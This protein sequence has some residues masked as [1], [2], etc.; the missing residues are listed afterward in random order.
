MALFESIT[1]AIKSIYSY[2]MR[3]V[4]TMLGI[5]IGISSVIMITSI[6]DGVYQ[7][8]Y[9]EL[10]A[11]NTTSI[12]AM[13]RNMFGPP[14]LELDDMHAAKALPNVINVTGML[15]LGG[16][17]LAL[18][19][20]GEFRRGS[21]WGLDHNYGTLENVNMLYGRFITQQDVDAEAFVAVISPEVS[22]D[23]F[24][25]VDSVG[26]TLQVTGPRGRYRL[27][28][29]GILDI[30]PVE[31]APQTP[32]NLSMFIVPLT[33]AGALRNVPGRIDNFSLSVENPF[34]SLATA[35][36]VARLLNIR[37]GTDD[38]FLVMS[39]TEIMDGIDVIFNGVTGFI[40]FVAGISLFVGGV[41]VMNIMMVTVTER[42]R[43]IGI[44]KSLGATGMLIRLQFVFEAIFITFIGGV[45][46]IVFGLLGAAALTTAATHFSG[47]SIYAYVDITAIIIAVVVS[48]LV[49]LVFGVYPAAKAANLDPVD[50]LR[51]E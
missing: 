28:V 40:A 17:Q 47:M 19:T 38:A 6:G 43:E 35:D 49:G 30:S 32:L 23:V 21:G 42:T 16:Q 20:P 22:L 29:V 41:G 26:H 48:V 24:G 44:R 7:A 36:Q 34:L 5:I 15:E 12:Q 3:S 46:G 39:A 10:E 45:I 2:K 1:S 50:S 8:I 27:T 9:S 25:F 14:I 51:Y 4:L 13:P 18:R 11:F 37:H 31:M 33:T